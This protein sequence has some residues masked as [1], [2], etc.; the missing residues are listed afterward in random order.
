MGENNFIS[1]KIFGFNEFEVTSSFDEQQIDISKVYSYKSIN[2]VTNDTENLLTYNIDYSIPDTYIKF[3]SF[4]EYIHRALVNIEN[5]YPHSLHISN[6]MIGREV[7]DNNIYDIV[8]DGENTTFKINTNYIESDYLNY[9]IDSDINVNNYVFLYNNIKYTILNFVGAK[10]YR[11]SFIELKVSGNIF[12]FEYALNIDGYITP[13][14]KYQITRLNKLSGF[15]QYITQDKF[16]IQDYYEGDVFDFSFKKTFSFPKNNTYQLDFKSK[17]YEEFKNDLFNIAEKYDEKLNI[18]ERLLIPTSIQDVEYDDLG[19]KT[20]GQV[21]TLLSIISSSFDRIYEKINNLYNNNE[22]YYALADQYRL[23]FSNTRKYVYDILLK[24]NIPEELIEFNEYVYTTQPINYDVIKKI[25]NQYKLNIA[26]YNL[27]VSDLGRPLIKNIPGIFQEKNYFGPLKNLFSQV[28]DIFLTGETIT[29][30]GE[31]IYTYTPTLSGEPLDLTLSG[32]DLTNAPC[33][34]LSS[35]IQT[36]SAP[37][38]FYDECGCE[39]DYIDYVNNIHIYPQSPY[40]NNCK[41][42][43]IDIVPEC[44][45]NVTTGDTVSGET[46]CNYFYNILSDD[47]IGN[48]V[49]LE[50]STLGLNVFYKT[51]LTSTCFDIQELNYDQII[52]IYTC[53]DIDILP[54]SGYVSTLRLYDSNLNIPIDININPYTSPNLIGCSGTVNANDLLFPDNESGYTAWETAILTIIENAICND[55][56]HLGTPENNLNYIIDVNILEDKIRICCLNKHNPSIDYNIGINRNDASITYGTSGETIVSNINS[57]YIDDYNIIHTREICD[58]LEINKV[59]YGNEII[60]VISVNYNEII[61]NEEHISL[62]ENGSINEISCIVENSANEINF[63]YG[64]YLNLNIYGGKAPFTVYGLNE[65]EIY[66]TGVTYSVFVE[67]ADGCVSNT[68]SG[69]VICPVDICNEYTFIERS[70]TIFVDV[71]VPSSGN[72]ES[73]PITFDLFRYFYDGEYNDPVPETFQVYYS[74]NFVNPFDVPVTL[75]IHIQSGAGNY[76]INTSDPDHFEIFN[77]F[78][79]FAG[80]SDF[81]VSVQALVNNQ[82]TY[83]LVSNTFNVFDEFNVP[84]NTLI[85]PITSS[86]TTIVSSGVTETYIEYGPIRPHLNASYICN[87]DGTATLHTSISGGYE[88][89]TYFGGFNNAIV[90]NNQVIELYVR[91]ANGCES[92]RVTLNIDCDP[93]IECNPLIFDARLETTSRDLTGKNA[94]LTFSYLID[95][96][97]AIEEVTVV[98]SAQ[99]LAANYMIGNPVLSVFQGEFG[100]NQLFFDFNPNDF[101]PV[102]IKFIVIIKLESGCEYKTTFNLSVNPTILSNTDNYS[103][104]LLI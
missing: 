51:R 82:C 94:T 76:F 96:A 92:N 81:L 52:E 34:L 55:F 7:G 90:N 63:E 80:S 17:Y 98:S 2:Y 12:P 69:L 102:T 26:N 93:P 50:V 73:I 19:N 29:T 57:I 86:G 15:E 70:R 8:Y 24:Y 101:I 100:A 72:C 78:P 66:T 45:V 60:D 91:G 21:N 62:Y 46:I 54:A 5:N 22:D 28:D 56:S 87:D 38:V 31:N 32:Y 27:P 18:T 58:I 47:D 104:E 48:N 13:N 6:F 89:Y 99:G 25:Y 65:E 11:N 77:T 97:T 42:F 30:S 44:I 37:T 53:Y 9:L 23:S 71:E 36:S 4:R 95:G 33:I 1:R 3:G 14:E 39:I 74:H 75:M 59:L 41:S 40:H 35:E 84:Y 16:S 49:R 10:T 83:E 85:D 20:I 68:V 79:A 88:P 103:K 67:D 43:V 61:L 64:A